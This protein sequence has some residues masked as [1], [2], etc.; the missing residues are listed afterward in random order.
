MTR[1]YVAVQLDLVT[2][3]TGYTDPGCQAMPRLCLDPLATT[4]A[5]AKLQAAHLRHSSECL[6]PVKNFSC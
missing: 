1:T 3:R 6:L 4:W 2:Y 5:L